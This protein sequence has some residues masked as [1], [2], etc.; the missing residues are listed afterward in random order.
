MAIGQTRILE[1]RPA[2][3]KILNENQWLC[4]A[5]EDSW[6]FWKNGC[7]LVIGLDAHTKTIQR[8]CVHSTELHYD[9]RELHGKSNGWYL[10][11]DGYIIGVGQITSGMMNALLFSSAQKK[12]IAELTAFVYKINELANM[13]TEELLEHRRAFLEI[14]QSVRRKAFVEYDG[15]LRDTMMFRTVMPAAQLKQGQVYRIIDI[16]DSNAVFIPVELDETGKELLVTEDRKSVLELSILKASIEKGIN[17]VVTLTEQTVPVAQKELTR[18]CTSHTAALP[19]YFQQFGL[20]QQ[21]KRALSKAVAMC[22]NVTPLLSRNIHAS[23]EFIQSLLQCTQ[24]LSVLLKCSF[25]KD[26]SNDLAF[27]IRNGLN[28]VPYV[29]SVINADYLKILLHDNEAMWEEYKTEH[30]F[31]SMYENLAK[32][33]FSFGKH[34]TNDSNV[35]DEYV[36]F[37]ADPLGLGHVSEELLQNG[38]CSGTRYS[39]AWNM[40]KNKAALYT[41]FSIPGMTLKNGVAWSDVLH[42]IFENALYLLFDVE[43]GFVVMS[44][45]CN[46]G[47]DYNSVAILD[48]MYKPVWRAI[49][50]NEKNIQYG[51]FR[52]SGFDSTD[53]VK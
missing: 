8:G 48:S 51:T 15:K 1:V 28:L 18:V 47:R 29:S 23:D 11:K 36:R 12:N 32:I 22:V 39:I 43:L 7:I 35:L 25:D 49:V 31:S 24:D 16:R 37:T 30:I 52:C 40:V 2:L 50:I 3:R 44:S 42:K 19:E 6:V 45:I 53:G 5:N 4:V 21:Q 27:L 41:Y 38:I 34:I 14:E 33:M 17:R 46:I 10:E 20:D 26:I 9:P 13:T